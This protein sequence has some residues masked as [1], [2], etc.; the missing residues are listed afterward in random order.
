[1]RWLLVLV[2]SALVYGLAAV[3]WHVMMGETWADS[4]SFALTLTVS[5]VTG[6]WLADAVLRRAGRDNG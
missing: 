1:M 5:A 2:V 4:L 6:R 3:W